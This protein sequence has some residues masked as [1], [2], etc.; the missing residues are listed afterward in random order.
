MFH[1]KNRLVSMRTHEMLREYDALCAGVCRAIR[2]SGQPQ[3]YYYLTLGIS[4]TTFH[5]RMR[6]ERWTLEELR[7]LLE[8]V[9]E[10]ERRPWWKRVVKWG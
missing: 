4:R 3:K 2:R 10:V 5:R 7:Q 6:D 8:M 1:L 9:G